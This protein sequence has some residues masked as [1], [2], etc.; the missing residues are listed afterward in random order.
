[1]APS[2][3]HGPSSAPAGEVSQGCQS[4]GHPV[5]RVPCSGAETCVSLWSLSREERC[6]QEPERDA[7]IP[8]H[9]GPG[10]PGPGLGRGEQGRKRCWV[11]L[12]GAVGAA[13]ARG[14]VA[15]H[16][17][18]S[19]GD[20]AGRRRTRGPRSAQSR[21]RAGWLCPQAD[22]VPCRQLPPG[23][24][25]LRRAVAPRAPGPSPGGRAEG[26]AGAGGPWLTA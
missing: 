20:P 23:S 4:L 13:G 19:Q 21:Q 11:G 10:Y 2:P 22:P 16:M 7:Q 9:R 5:C 17:L 14:P 12:P 3:E 15:G 24:G 1:M 25:G 8:G 6:P 26:G 18:T